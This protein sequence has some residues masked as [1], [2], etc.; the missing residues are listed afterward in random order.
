MLRVTFADTLTRDQFAD[1]Y[2]LTSQVG[3]NQLDIGWHLLQAVKLD[4]NALDYDEIAALTASPEANSLQEFIVKGDP[5]I[6]GTYATV[7]NDL[8]KGFYHVA[9]S[10][11]T[12][13]GDYVDSIEHNNYGMTFLGS[14][15]TI[16]EM[17]GTDSDI[18][19]T[20]N[21]GQWARIRIASKYRPLQEQ[22]T[23]HDITYQSK[24]ELYIID[25]GIDFTHDEFNY[26]GIETENFYTL[27]V[28][29]GDFNDDIGHGTAVASM[30]CGKNLGVAQHLK[31]ISVKIGNEQHKATLVEVG[32]AIDAIVA[33]ASASPLV[34]RIVN[35]SWGISRSSWLDAKVQGLI[36][37]GITVTCS[38]GNNGI[39]VELVSPAGINDVITVASIDRYDI[40]SGFNNISPSDEGVTTGHGLNLDIFAPGEAVLLAKPGGGYVMGSGTSFSSPLVAGVATVIG[41]C[42]SGFVSGIDI[43]NQI[44]DTAT[45]DALLF[46]DDKFSENQNRLV[47]LYTS[48]PNGN[49]HSDNVSMYLGATTRDDPLV[50]DVN[51]NLDLSVIKQ[52]HSNLDVVYSIKWSDPQLETDYSPFVTCNPVTGVITIAKPTVALPESTKL[53]MVEFKIQASNSIITA[54]TPNLFFFHTNSQYADTAQQDITLALT[55]TN[56]ISFMATWYNSIK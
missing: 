40:P 53:K 28:F 47:Y 14:P 33:R 50:I 41:S 42:N 2:K 17:N 45:L 5:A 56:S 26:E 34:T 11:G 29:N 27:P 39:D 35:M 1:K 7:I 20:S 23:I 3:E 37:M 24:P 18:D 13:L 55:D 36:D 22:F 8:G 4:P 43:K 48:D 31:L 16:S 6:F 19:P 44:L 38:A 9:S 25:S 46:E 12:L 54:T 52:M 10:D 32:E 49:Y 51:S 21:N 15:S 30:A